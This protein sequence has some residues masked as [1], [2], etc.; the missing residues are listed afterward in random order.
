MEGWGEGFL[1]F[2][3]TYLGK[4]VETLAD[5]KGRT[6]ERKADSSPSYARHLANA[7]RHMKAIHGRSRTGSLRRRW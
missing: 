4:P 5:L 2:F 6:R 3:I 1:A 7:G